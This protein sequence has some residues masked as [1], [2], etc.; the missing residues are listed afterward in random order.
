MLVR[1]LQTQG[2]AYQARFANSDGGFTVLRDVVARHWRS[3]QTLVALLALLYGYDIDTVS[4]HVTLDSAQFVAS[5]ETVSPYAI[6]IARCVLSAVTMGSKAQSLGEETPGVVRENGEEMPAGKPALLLDYLDRVVL[7]D[8]DERPI[9]SPVV[10][11]DLYDRLQ[12]LL[13]GPPVTSFEEI[14]PAAQHLVTE[15]A[16]IAVRRIL[17]R[18]AL[19]TPGPMIA[20][21]PSSDAC[22]RPLRAIFDAAAATEQVDGVRFRTLLL[23]RSIEMLAQTHIT[24]TTAGRVEAFIDATVGFAF[25]GEQSPPVLFRRITAEVLPL[26]W[27]DRPVVLLAFALKLAEQVNDD[28]ALVAQKATV[29]L[30]SRLMS[31]VDRLALL[32]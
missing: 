11:R 6:D 7:E 29:D 12:P 9:E 16:R 21:F 19:R 31:S 27:M 30:L 23:E 10:L 2:S 13:P 1:L 26:G 32:W 28:N 5:P 8:T 15:F 3:D 4:L 18:D 17:A 25:Q 22:L 14:S 20:Q 24:A